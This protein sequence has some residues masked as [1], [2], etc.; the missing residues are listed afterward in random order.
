MKI[1][2]GKIIDKFEELVKPQMQITDL[3]EKL[4]GIANDML[5]NKDNISSILSRFIEFCGQDVI[6][7]YYIKFYMRFINKYINELKIDFDNPIIDLRPVAHELFPKLKN[8]QLD[9]LSKRLHVKGNNDTEITAKILL[10]FIKKIY[11]ISQA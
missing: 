4:T 8:F 10:K 7:A 9:N 11:G 5:K 2:N 6:V 3:V 1:I